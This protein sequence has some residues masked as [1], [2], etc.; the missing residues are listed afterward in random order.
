MTLLK[1]FAGLRILKILLYMVSA[2][3]IYT[4]HLNVDDFNLL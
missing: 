4:G 1:P 2:P 3:L